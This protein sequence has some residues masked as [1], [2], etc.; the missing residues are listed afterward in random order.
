MHLFAFVSHV[1]EFLVG[2]SYP[3]SCFA[4]R[5]WQ[6]DSTF[7]HL[8]FGV[9]VIFGFCKLVVRRKKVK[10]GPKKAV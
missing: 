5:T 7:F 2:I 3:L 10:V 1:F 8:I 9:Y 6:I 4:Q